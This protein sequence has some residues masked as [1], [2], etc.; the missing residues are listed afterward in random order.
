MIAEED[1]KSGE[2]SSVRSRVVPTE[3]GNADLSPSRNVKGK[4]LCGLAR[5]HWLPQSQVATDEEERGKKKKSWRGRPW[6]CVLQGRRGRQRNVSLSVASVRDASN[7]EGALRVGVS[8]AVRLENNADAQLEKAAYC[9]SG[10]HL[11]CWR[12]RDYG[13]ADSWASLCCCARA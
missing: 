11:N 3:E 5:A 13:A 8:I 4:I 9:V 12:G 2:L 6:D 1:Q 10:W 7:C